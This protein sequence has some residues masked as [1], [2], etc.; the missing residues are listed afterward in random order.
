MVHLK[1]NF[2]V[3]GSSYIQIWNL[4]SSNEGSSILINGFLLTVL[5]DFSFVAYSGNGTLAFYNI[6][7]KDL[8]FQKSFNVLEIVAL[9]VMKNGDLFLNFVVSFQK[10][11]LL[12]LKSFSTLNTFLELNSLIIRL[13]CILR[14][15]RKLQKSSSSCCLT[16]PIE[17]F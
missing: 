13:F 14:S 10:R 17:F 16:I 6:L 2:L 7:K 12:Y 8:I 9:N 11:C 15:P 1:I 4:S 5:D 3:I